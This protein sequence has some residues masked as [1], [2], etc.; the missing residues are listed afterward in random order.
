MMASLGG[1]EGL[2][3]PLY[4]VLLVDIGELFIMGGLPLI[5]VWVQSRMLEFSRG[6]GI[7]I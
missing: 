2:M 6:W 3:E 4:A 5:G 1:Y 7:D